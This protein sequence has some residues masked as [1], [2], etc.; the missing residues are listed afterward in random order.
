MNVLNSNLT[1]LYS[2]FFFAAVAVTAED[3]SHAIPSTM[4][5]SIVVEAPGFNDTDI[6]KSKA[7]FPLRLLSYLKDR[8]RFHHI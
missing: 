4:R 3:T 2:Y 7:Y 8:L 1:N 6:V 5:V